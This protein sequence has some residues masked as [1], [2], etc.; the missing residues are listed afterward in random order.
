MMTSMTSLIH[1]CRGIKNKNTYLP[2][3]Y[4]HG[5]QDKQLLYISTRVA[6]TSLQ[7]NQYFHAC[8][9][10]KQENVPQLVNNQP[11]SF[12]MYSQATSTV[13]VPLL[14]TLALKHHEL[15]GD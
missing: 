2:E 1:P 10:T 13:F 11:W 14:G 3:Y 5:Q 6:V 12:L 15:F 8:Q 7:G 4:D 9:Q